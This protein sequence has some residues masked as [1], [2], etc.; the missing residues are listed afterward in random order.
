MQND[1][2]NK[3]L[4]RIAVQRYIWEKHNSDVWQREETTGYTYIKGYL[5]ALLTIFGLD[6][7]ED[8]EKIIIQTAVKKKL[9]CIVYLS[10]TIDMETGEQEND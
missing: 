8:K 9:W 1:I 5:N 6:M 3:E 7:V 2:P 10:E 4:V